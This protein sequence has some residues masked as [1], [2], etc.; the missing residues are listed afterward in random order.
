VGSYTVTTTDAEDLGIQH[1]AGLQGSLD[2]AVFFDNQAHAMILPWAQRQQASVA[3]ASAQDVA[4][5]YLA[6]DTATQQ[7]VLNTLG[8]TSGTP[9][10]AS[11]TP[12]V[13]LPPG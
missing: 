9:S 6:A 8:M 7:E 1:Q 4:T 11:S 2:P 13:V 5:A 3:P 12:M 10:T